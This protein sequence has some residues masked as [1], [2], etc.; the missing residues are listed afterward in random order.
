MRRPW[1]AAPRS[2]PRPS[3]RRVSGQLLLLASVIASAVAV[4]CGGGD[5]APVTPS[6]GAR[7]VTATSTAAPPTSTGPTAT[8]RPGAAPTIDPNRTIAANTGQTV[9]RNGGPEPRLSIPSSRFLAAEE[10]IP[11]VVVASRPDTFP[12]N[13]ELFAALG[14]FPTAAEGAVLAAEWKYVE[15]YATT[16]EPDGLLAGVLLGRYFV[17]IEAHLFETA[18]GAKAAFARYVEAYNAAPRSEEQAAP[19]TGNESAAWRIYAGKVGTSTT[20]AVY[21]RVVFRR[22]NLLSVVQTI[23]A[24]PVMTVAQVAAIA[25]IV[26]QRA[27]GGR[28]ASTPTPRPTAKP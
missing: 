13:V 3:P 22:G 17:L 15:G 5:D 2:S 4:A 23:G 20:D 21:H 28:P 8:A 10:E 25:A 7:P 18:D 24:A 14:P 12:V 16:F 19:G 26:D 27:M 1:I 9:V 11:I 6:A